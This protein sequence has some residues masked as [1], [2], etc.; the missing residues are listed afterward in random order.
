MEISGSGILVPPSLPANGDDPRRRRRRYQ[1][2]SPVSS[3]EPT[4]PPTTPPA[5][6]PA[7]DFFGA[8]LELEELWG[9]ADDV[10]DGW[11][12]EGAIGVDSGES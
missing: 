4:T 11:T 8:E 10:D 1:K 6:C 2:I 9:A 7:C 5:I 12:V 3:A